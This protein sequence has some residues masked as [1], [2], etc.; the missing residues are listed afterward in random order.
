MG[1]LLEGFGVGIISYTVP[2]YIAEISPQNMRGCLGSVNQ[3]AVTIGIMLAY[4][5]GL[6]VNWRVLA[7]LGILPCI[8]LMP[9]L[10]FIP[11]SPRWLAKMGMAEDFEASLQVLRGFDTDISIEVNQI[12]VLCSTCQLLGLGPSS[13]QLGTKYSK[14]Y[15]IMLFD[16][17]LIARRSVA[18]TS[19]RATIRFSDLKGR[20]IATFT[21]Y[22]LVA[23]F[24]VVF[25]ALWVPETKGR[26]LE[27]FRGHLDD[28]FPEAYIIHKSGSEVNFMH[29]ASRRG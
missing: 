24:T 15:T 13:C 21:I 12:K 28:S 16:D 18:S 1:R 2:V 5:L 22:T 9:G 14:F 25:V 6:F 17:K 8:I 3:L 4:L 27:R 11:E 26:T 7:I 29:E 23:A 19:K 10:F 20:E